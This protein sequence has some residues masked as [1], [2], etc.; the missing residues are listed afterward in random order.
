MVQYW[1]VIAVLEV[2]P[3]AALG[4][5]DRIKLSR[6]RVLC[7]APSE[8]GEKAVAQEDGE[9]AQVLGGVCNSDAR[10]PRSKRVL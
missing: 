7:G 2:G 8:S 1:A 6:R 5:V 9:N 10:M 3:D 4:L